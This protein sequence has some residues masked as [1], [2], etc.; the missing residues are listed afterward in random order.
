M[1]AEINYWPTVDQNV[2]PLF[3]SKASE[4]SIPTLYH[5]RKYQA[6]DTL[7]KEIALAQH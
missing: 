6:M 4:E 7:S 3:S 5:H 2:W 1:H